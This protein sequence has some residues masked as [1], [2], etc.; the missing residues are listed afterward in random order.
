[1]EISSDY[2]LAIGSGVAREIL[3]SLFIR[4]SIVL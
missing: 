3:S 4:Q 1:M 2:L